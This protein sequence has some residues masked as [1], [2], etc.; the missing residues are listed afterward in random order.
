MADFS[1]SGI[2]SAIA[3]FRR[4]VELDHS[5][6]PGWAG[7]SGAYVLA[8]YLGYL[9]AAEAME[10]AGQAAEEALKIDSRLALAH[11]ALGWVRLVDF[12]W[13]KARE[14]FETALSLNPNDVDALHG[15]GD[16]LTVTGSED[17]GMDYVRR[18]RANDPF[19]PV[20]GHSV[21]GHLHMMRRFE[22][23][24]SESEAVLETFPG[25][26]VRDRAFEGRHVVRPDR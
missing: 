9:P 6:A 24:L 16:Y 7:L 4:A 12:E 23:L 1:R 17:A 19:S 13:E 21:V 8:A 22:E 11:T 26:F 5:Y 10:Q 15:L 2:D 14:S 20:W 18:A 3:Y 25:P